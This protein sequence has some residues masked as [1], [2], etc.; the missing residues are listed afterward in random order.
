M[1]NASVFEQEAIF[2]VFI[3]N[4]PTPKTLIFGV[5]HVYYKKKH[6]VKHI[7]I[8]KPQHF[9]EWMY[10][11]NLLN[12]LLPYNLRTLRHAWKQFKR[13][14]GLRAFKYRLD[15]YDDY[16]PDTYDLDSARRLIYGSTTP[17][18]RQP[19][20]SEE[21]VSP[22]EI[23]A[24]RYPALE[25]LKRMLARL[26]HDT[27]KIVLLVPYHYYRQAVPGSREF[28]RLEEFKKRLAGA[29]CRVPKA[30]LLD[31]MIESP[32]TSRDENYLDGL[33]YT[34]GAATLIAR[35]MAIGVFE[36]TEDLNFVRVCPRASEATAQGPEIP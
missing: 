15:G 32:I 16:S 22:Q 26:P 24:F 28:I 14:T 5:D 9:P 7:G 35:S 8:I 11:E 27:L 34:A 25:H 31:F 20:V 21:T 3:R 19:F 6:Y 2:Q 18:R 17:K 1:N 23:E 29:V 4:H 30:Y 13:C 33:H 36:R 12:D 10:D